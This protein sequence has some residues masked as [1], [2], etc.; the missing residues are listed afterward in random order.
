MV[1]YYLPSSELDDVMDPLL[2]V[3]LEP[4]AKPSAHSLSLIWFLAR[5]GQRRHPGDFYFRLPNGFI[6]DER[7][8]DGAKLRVFVYFI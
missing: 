6:L 3:C 7:F 1:I 8:Q 4:V 5:V 2:T